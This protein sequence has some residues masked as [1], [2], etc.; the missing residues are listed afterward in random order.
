MTT[1]LGLASTDRPAN[2]QPAGASPPLL[3]TKTSKAHPVSPSIYSFSS[4]MSCL[5]SPAMPCN[6]NLTLCGFIPL[7]DPHLAVGMTKPGPIRCSPCGIH[8][9]YFKLLLRLLT[10]NHLSRDFPVPNLSSRPN[11]DP[12]SSASPAKEKK[13]K[14]LLLT[15]HC[16]I[17]LSTSLADPA[18]VL[19]IYCR[20]MAVQN[21]TQ[22]PA[23][24][25]S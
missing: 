2:F 16:V 15:P 20:S 13:K 3:H 8:C 19:Y 14:P 10:V 25:T 5:L 4:V 24:T 1:A 7:I 12:N 17:D 22:I 18:A 6:F 21:T 11:T 9:F 23:N